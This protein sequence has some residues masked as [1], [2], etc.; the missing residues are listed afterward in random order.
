MESSVLTEMQELRHKIALLAAQRNDALQ[1][2]AKAQEE[3][4]D[5]KAEL[6]LTKEELHKKNLDVEYLSVSHKLADTPEAL[7]EARKTVRRMISGV[8][9]ALALLRNDPGL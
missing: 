2:L 4:G 3:I 1:S 6:E 8:D 9:K 7:A 5:L